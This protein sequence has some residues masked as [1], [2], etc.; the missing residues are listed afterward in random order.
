MLAVAAH[1]N[2]WWEW[3]A[4]PPLST[5]DG[6]PQGLGE[7]LKDPVAGMERWRLGIPRLAERHP[8]ASLLIGDHAHW[9]YEA[10]F[11]PNH[12][13]E[14]THQLLVGRAFYP[15]NRKRRHG[16]FWTTPSAAP[17]YQL[18]PQK[19]NLLQNPGCLLPPRMRL[20][21]PRGN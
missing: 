11:N 20:G 18:L 4:D 9:L 15:G 3:E 16:G 1:D 12:P 14:L 5:E 8:Y 21:H 10:Q 13:P 6:L 17:E 2:G 19:R 7:V